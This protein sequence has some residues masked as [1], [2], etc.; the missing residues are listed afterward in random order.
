M[1]QNRYPSPII[2]ISD[3]DTRTDSSTEADSSWWG[4]ENQLGLQPGE[5]FG[6]RRD[7]EDD[8]EEVALDK[9]GEIKY[10]EAIAKY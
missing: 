3:E 7:D 5:Q 8:D 10:Y 4:P 6:S 1:V 9:K 2:V